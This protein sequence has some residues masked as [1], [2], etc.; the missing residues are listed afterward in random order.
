MDNEPSG[1]FRYVVR[2]LVHASATVTTPMFLLNRR[3]AFK[4]LAALGLTSSGR[5]DL[6]AATERSQPRRLLFNWDGSLV[7]CFGRAA[8]GNPDGP[9]TREQ[10]TSLVFD[11][12][13][14][15]SVDAILFSFGSGNVA[16]FQSQTLE[17]PG[18]ADR[19]Q[20]PE[21]KKWHGA[22]EV[23]PADQYR[24]PQA[25]AAAGHNPPDIIIAECRK[26]GID[27]F[28][29]LRMNDCHDGQHP[30]GVLPNPE[31]ATFKRQ[32]PDW[33]VAD[34]DCWTAL[35]FRHPRVRQLKLRVINEFFD[36]W[37]FDGIELDWLRHTL[38]LPR[39][40]EKEN[41]HFLTEFMREIRTLLRN[42]AQKRGRPIEVAVRIPE[43]VAWCDEGGF[44][45]G[46]W[47]EEDLA[48]LLILGQGL[49]ELPS[50]TE[51]RDLMRDKQL[52]IYPCLSPYGNGY[53]VS[54]DEVIRG[55][56]ANLWNAGADGIYTF[57]WG[58]YGPWRSQLV[59]EISDSSRLAGKNRRHTMVHRM[60]VEDGTG[61]NSDYVRYN[62][63]RRNAQLPL[64]W[65]PK[66]G[67]QEMTLSVSADS[68]SGLERSPE[69]ELWLGF[70]FL[71]EMDQLDV[72]VNGRQVHLIEP[73]PTL[74]M[75]RL[76]EPMR[77]PSGNG[78]LGV[79]LQ[80]PIDNTFMG[81]RYVVPVN[82]LRAGTNDITLILMQRLATLKHRLRL[83][84]VEL[85][86]TF[87]QTT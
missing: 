45:I 9:I 13:A 12:L 67:P 52:P 3:T 36:R 68:L 20:F 86:V 16:E 2:N 63:Q 44:E 32:N 84:R 72:E 21:S 15:E 87:P 29:S 60:D 81:L 5:R 51:F 1:R 27:A 73:K 78:M 58:F 56:A 8:L 66:D 26:R 46:K 31:L 50:L 49:T 54:P 77:V 17:W 62:T 7:H 82:Q 61:A 48:D 42:R 76:G 79:H 39:G 41:G 38:N 30:R 6:Q 64:S 47:I 10:F 22:I 4:I 83:T 65:Q 80:D 59:R 43:R 85:N 55:S 24:N 19:Y 35:D 34:L 14:E 74:V 70:D 11:G 53:Q 28:V 23:D 18:Q 57:N 33:L 25:L 75:E 71:H 37:D 69:I 40:T